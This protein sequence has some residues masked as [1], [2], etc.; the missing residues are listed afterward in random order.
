MGWRQNGIRIARSARSLTELRSE[1]AAGDVNEDAAA[2]VRAVRRSLEPSTLL[3]VAAEITVFV[4]S[5]S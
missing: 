5:S 2:I 3:E 4:K 1:V